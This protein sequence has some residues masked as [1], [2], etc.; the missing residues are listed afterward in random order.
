MPSRIPTH[1][2][3][4]DHL[5]R[6]ARRT[7]NAEASA[8]RLEANR[9]YASVRWRRLRKVFLL[10]HP[11]CYECQRR[12][13]LIPAT[14]VHHVDERRLRPELALEWNKLHALCA[15]CHGSKRSKGEGG[16]FLL[17]GSPS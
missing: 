17:D 15:P 6:G 7:L 8:D 13:L 3:L 11:L 16:G 14:Q 10:Q 5:S 1:Q 2:S 12:G 4:A 9:F